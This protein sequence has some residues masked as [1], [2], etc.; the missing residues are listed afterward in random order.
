MNLPPPFPD[1]EEDRL[2]ALL[3]YEIL[4]TEAEQAFDDLTAI[5][6]HICNIPISLISLVDGKYKLPALT[7]LKDWFLHPGQ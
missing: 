5:A 6:A 2:R 7:S 3:E 4:D 1:N